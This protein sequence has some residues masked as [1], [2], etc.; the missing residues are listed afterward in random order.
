[1]VGEIVATEADFRD[2]AVN[3]WG[4][5]AGPYDARWRDLVQ[6]LLLDGYTV[7][8]HRLVAVDPDLQGAGH[9]EDALTAEVK[10]SG[11]PTAAGIVSVLEQSAKAFLQVPPDYNGCLSNARTAL[12][13]LATEIAEA[14]KQKLGGSFQANKWGQVLEYLRTSHLIT[15]IEEDLIGAVYGFISQGA[16]QPVGLSKEEMVRLGRGMALSICY[17]LVKLHN[18]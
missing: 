18:A 16:H 13:T 10:R 11:L 7:S 5:G 1:M 15:G 9:I 8:K 17:F 4:D 6:C 3:Q 2:H 12:Q 14:R